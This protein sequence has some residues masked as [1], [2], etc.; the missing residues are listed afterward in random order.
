VKSFWNKFIKRNHGPHPADAEITKGLDA[1]GLPWEYDADDDSYRLENV[2]VNPDNFRRKWD[3]GDRSIAS[4]VEN[5]VRA[6]QQLPKPSPENIYLK[7]RPVDQMGDLEPIAEIPKSTEVCYGLV[8][9]HPHGDDFLIT[10]LHKSDLEALGMTLEQAIAQAGENLDAQLEEAS[11]RGIAD[12]SAPYMIETG[13]T[14][15]S[16]FVLAPSF[17]RVVEPVVGWPVMFIMPD[18]DYLLL[19]SESFLKETPQIG[20]AVMREFSE[21]PYPLTTE[22]FEVNDEGV[23]CRGRF[24]DS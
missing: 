18:D 16:A 13:F 4:A 24:Y 15:K 19:F 3:A 17:R 12:G 9:V 5:M 20:A 21:S 1:A 7:F 10:W 8:A 2:G 23:V 22:L 6:S 14:F 11:V